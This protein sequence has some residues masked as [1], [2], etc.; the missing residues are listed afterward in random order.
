MAVQ[1]IFE[2]QIGANSRPMLVPA[3]AT[4]LNSQRQGR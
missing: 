4:K 1:L 2:S 3:S